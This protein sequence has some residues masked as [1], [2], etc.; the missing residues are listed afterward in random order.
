MTE[1]RIDCGACVVRSWSWED[2]PALVRH[3][4]N[5]R[6]WIGLRDRFPHPYSEA[7]GRQ[8]LDRTLTARPETNFAIEVEGEAAGG[9]GLVLGVDVERCSAELGYWVGEAFWGRGVATAAVRGFTPWAFSAFPLSRIFAVP[10]LTNSA[11]CRV[12]ENAGYVR[13]GV[14]RSSAI[15]EGVLLHQAMYAVVRES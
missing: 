4:N 11:S 9:I 2:L 1:L 5:R 8:F 12:L 15:K 3:A 6:V 10:F 14:L 13:E 7:D